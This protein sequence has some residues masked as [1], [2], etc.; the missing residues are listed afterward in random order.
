MKRSFEFLQKAASVLRKAWDISRRISAALWEAF[1]W[2]IIPLIFGYL[3]YASIKRE[4]ELSWLQICVAGIAVSPW[5]LK[6][7]ARYFSE[8]NIG[9]K[10]LSA[11]TKQAVINKDEIKPPIIW[12]A[13]AVPPPQSEF[14]K[15]P[16]QQKKV[17]RTL[18]KYQVEHFGPE[19]IRRW[20]FAVGAAAPDYAEFRD[21]MFQLDDKKLIAM[22]KRG[23]VFLTNEGIEF[24]TKNN[25]EISC[26]PFFYSDFS[27]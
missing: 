18:W 13:N 20:G 12:M 22:D 6:L 4:F 5:I 17:L 14:A 26:Y 19:D 25:Q 3:C 2:I 10:G 23:F 9:P 16:P 8:F 21:G 24:C 7:L 1:C 27:N 11:K 15:L